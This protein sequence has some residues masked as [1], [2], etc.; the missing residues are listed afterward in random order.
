MH[1]REDISTDKLYEETYAFLC[2]LERF[3]IL[4][5][6][7]NISDLLGKLGDP[8]LDY[9]TVHV[10][11]SN[12]KGST[13]S[14]LS[15]I[16]RSA[17]LRTALYTSPHLND[18]RER[19]RIDGRMVSKESV[20]S[21]T[22][23]AREVYDPERTTFFEFTTA[24]AFQCL[25]EARPDMAVIEVGLGGRLDATNTISPLLSIITDISREHEDYLGHGLAS[26]ATEKAGIIKKGVPLVT[27]ATRSEARE[28]ILGRAKELGSEAV[29]FGR[30]FVGLRTG[31][32]KF[33]YKSPDLIVEDIR[34]SMPGGHQVKNA[35]MACAAAEILKRKGHKIDESDIRSGIGATRF[36]GR[37][38]LLRRSPDVIIDGAH[39][40]ES[41]R[42]LKSVFQQAY[43]GVRPKLLLG[44]LKEKNYREM[45][46]VVVPMASDVVCVAPQGDRAL[47]PA[48]LA[49]EVEK[50]GVPALVAPGIE[51]GLSMLVD[52]AKPEDVILAAGSLYMIGPVRRAC[53]LSDE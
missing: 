29:L 14:F 7:E 28:V 6:L 32:D 25:A 18:F 4:L 37:F 49:V 46:S 17:G 16:L 20:I 52:A 40:P 22:Q 44:A 11:G 24:V 8:Q 31:P 15:N 45:V 1:H 35:S 27:G 26:V 21:A 9:P 47:D 10:G 3:G 5:G 50:L 36:N 19:I 42:L 12:G 39:T 2:S 13:S 30:D 43:P 34:L 41:M 33:T 51:A 23:R 53:G 48:D 38:E